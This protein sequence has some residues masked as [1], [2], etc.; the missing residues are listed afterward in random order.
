MASPNS[1]TGIE[2]PSIAASLNSTPNLRASGS[3]MTTYSVAFTSFHRRMAAINSAITAIAGSRH[4]FSRRMPD[5]IPYPFNLI[6]VISSVQNAGH[7]V[8]S[9]GRAIDQT[10][11]LAPVP[12]VKSLTAP[13]PDPHRD[14]TSF[15]P[16]HISL[17]SA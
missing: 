11:A 12:N 14:S 6:S 10:P 1:S 2:D 17:G 8:E 9:D 3:K 5:R 16:A 13:K 4:P 15:V 7:C